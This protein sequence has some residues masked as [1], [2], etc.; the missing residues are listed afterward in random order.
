MRNKILDNIL[1]LLIT[2]SIL[3]VLLICIGKPYLENILLEHLTEYNYIEDIYYTDNVNPDEI[4]DI[5]NYLKQT[6]ELYEIFKED[7]GYVLY[8]DDLDKERLFCIQKDKA[9]GNF[10]KCKTYYKI[11]LQSGYSDQ[12]QSTVIHELG[13]YLD[14]KLDNVSNKKEFDVLFDK[15]KDIDLNNYSKSENYE[16]IISDKSEFFAERYS[17]YILYP[18][19]LKTVEPDLYYFI[20]ECLKE[21]LLW[22]YLFKRK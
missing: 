17:D 13:H 7:N 10:Q 20:E 2:L 8:T 16:Y 19:L 21:V 6:G 18:E 14:F 15:Y 1:S 5:K 12:L 4:D 22:E 9:I 11:T 3:L